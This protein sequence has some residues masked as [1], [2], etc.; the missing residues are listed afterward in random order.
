MN[1]GIYSRELELSGERIEDSRKSRGNWEEFRAAATLLNE[2]INSRGQKDMNSIHRAKDEK[3][4]FRWNACWS[5]W[6]FMARWH[7]VS[8]S[9]AWNAAIS[10]DVHI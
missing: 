1:T 9:D 3:N 8:L 6:T 4:E 5:L 7:A 10:I 2:S